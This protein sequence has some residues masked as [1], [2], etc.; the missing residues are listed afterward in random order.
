ML[1]SAEGVLGKG[2]RTCAL[3]GTSL[4]LSC[5][6]EHSTIP[7]WFKLDGTN[8]TEV[9]V[10]GSRLKH[11]ISKDTHPTLSF[12]G[13]TKDD[14]TSYCCNENS[15][16]C[17]KDHI[18]LTVTGKLDHWLTLKRKGLVCANSLYLSLHLSL[19]G[20]GVSHHRRTDGNSD[21]QHR[22]YSDW[23]TCCLHLVQELR[24]SLS[25]PV[26]MVSGDGHQWQNSQILLRHQRLWGS[27]SSCSHSG[28]V[29]FHWRFNHQSNPA[30]YLIWT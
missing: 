2:I 24:A 7:K 10:N 17:H 9:S 28:S 19:A 15:E 5:S 23:Q 16:N 26:S 1:L 18:Q 3:K 22:L 20:E 8:W 30:V 12:T 29:M 11:Q 27:R 14:K 6:A 25:R 4:N 13:L 21:V